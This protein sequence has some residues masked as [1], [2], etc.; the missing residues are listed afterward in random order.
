MLNN[1]RPKNLWT[2]VND[3]N[4]PGL[5]QRRQTTGSVGM[6]ENIIFYYNSNPFFCFSNNNL[7]SKSFNQSIENPYQMGSIEKGRLNWH[8]TVLL[9]SQAGR[10][11]KKVP[12]RSCNKQQSSKLSYF[13]HADFSQFVL[14]LLVYLKR[15]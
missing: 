9:R 6:Q 12:K 11:E 10:Q 4:Y 13:L 5:T 7:L 2:S 14:F 3:L 1:R 15:K 8:Y